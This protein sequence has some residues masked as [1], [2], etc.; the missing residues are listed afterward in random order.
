M[1]FLFSEAIYK[2]HFKAFLKLAMFQNINGA[3]KET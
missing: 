3:I 2:L 1:N